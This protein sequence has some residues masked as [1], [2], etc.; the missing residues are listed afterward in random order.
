MRSADLP[1][2][3]A[4]LL[5]AATAIAAAG[6]STVGDTLKSTRDAIA[7]A[8]PAAAPTSAAGTPAA[9]LRPPPEAPV[10]PAVKAAFEQASQALRS[11]R[12]AEAE[13]AFR[14][15]AQAHPDLGGPQANLGLLHRQA[16]RLDEAV[17]AFEQATRINPRQP[18]YFNHLGVA[19]R[20]QGRFAQAREAYE[21]AIA[22]DAGYAAPVL[23]LGILNDLYL[24]DG[25]R[26]LELYGRYLGLA[27]NDAN[28]AKWV[29]D[30]KNRKPAPMRVGMLQEKLE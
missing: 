21:R 9:P 8:A 4:R 5:V 27:G 15:L 29:T 13:R 2:G 26:A 25:A 19:Y 24:G 11:G 7:P 1:L 20:Q 10:A 30:L 28:V 17:A 3:M 22:L 12:V 18:I 16:G 14:A 23:N 6:C